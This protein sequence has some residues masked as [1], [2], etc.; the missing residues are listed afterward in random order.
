M[1]DDEEG[2]EEQAPEVAKSGAS[3]AGAAAATSMGR[4]QERK[5]GKQEE[6]VAEALMADAEVPETI[7]PA[8]SSLAEATTT[9]GAKSHK[10]GLGPRNNPIDRT[11]W[12]AWA[13]MEGRQRTS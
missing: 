7:V 6:E 12:K 4:K 10:D 3:T 2:G 11:A 9:A 8:A 5:G 1:S 13:E